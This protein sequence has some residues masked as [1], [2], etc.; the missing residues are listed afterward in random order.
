MQSVAISVTLIVGPTG[1]VLSGSTAK[2]SGS[3]R[4][5]VSQPASMPGGSGVPI[6]TRSGSGAADASGVGAADVWTGAVVVV[7]CG[8]GAGSAEGAPVGGMRQPDS[9][10]A[11]AATTTR[12]GAAGRRRVDDDM[13]GS[14]CR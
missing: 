6:A 7:G 12:S 2:A 3:V 4:M 14:R 10:S 5:L 1:K 9:D 13:A 8:A 11:A